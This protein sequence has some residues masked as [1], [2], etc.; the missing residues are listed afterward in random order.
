MSEI[1][2]RFKREHCEIIALLREVKKIGIHSKEGQAKLLSLK[3][4]LLEHLK[5]EDEQLYPALRKEAEHNKNLKRE[6]DLF[7]MDPEYVSRVV[8]EF[9][10]T[11]S[12]GGTGKDFSINFESLFA[13][14]NARITHEE[15]SLY[16]EYEMIGKK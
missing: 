13:A 14:L 3:G 7:A 6:L 4:V 8:A 2:E 10:D 9:F 5:H 15:E 1:I 16:Q 11:Y 12:E